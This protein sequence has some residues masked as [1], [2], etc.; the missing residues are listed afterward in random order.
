MRDRL[1]RAAIEIFSNPLT[2][3]L[4]NN[5]LTVVPFLICVQRHD[6]MAQRIRRDPLGAGHPNVYAVAEIAAT[7]HG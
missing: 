5:G 1:H 7:V 2:V 6:R 4:I 3:S